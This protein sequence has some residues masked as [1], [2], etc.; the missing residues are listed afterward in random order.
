M[1]WL[2]HY[3][4]PKSQWSDEARRRYDAQHRGGKTLPWDVAIR[5]LKRGYDEYQEQEAEARRE[6]RRQSRH[7]GDSEQ[8]RFNAAVSRAQNDVELWSNKPGRTRLTG[9]RNKTASRSGKASDWSEASSRRGKSPASESVSTRS[10]DPSQLRF[11]QASG[12]K[13]PRGHL[14]VDP[15]YKKPRNGNLPTAHKGPR[16]GSLTPTENTG[17]GLINRSRAKKGSKG[18]YSAKS[19]VGKNAS[20]GTKSPAA[21]STNSAATQI[22][23]MYENT[24]G[25]RR[26][27]GNLGRNGQLVKQ[28]QDMNEF[29]TRNGMQANSLRVTPKGHNKVIN[30]GQRTEGNGHSSLNPSRRRDINQPRSKKKK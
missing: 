14:N 22:G 23:R 6:R 21:R 12:Y 10:K 19:G 9:G 17:S 1:A 13:S 28:N 24:L 29:L 20:R 18:T 8:A 26:R 16:S 11:D 2:A 25:G 3:G 30:N 4:V 15:G 7:V 5:N 27:L